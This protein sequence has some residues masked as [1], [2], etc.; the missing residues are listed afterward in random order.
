MSFLI[1]GLG[2]G[3]SLS[4]DGNSVPPSSSN[5]NVQPTETPN[6]TTVGSL[7]VSTAALP[8][9]EQYFVDGSGRSLYF[10]D[11]DAQ[12]YSA[13][14]EENN[15]ISAWPPYTVESDQSVIAEGQAVQVDIG[16]F[17]RED[18]GISSTQVTYQ[19]YPLYSYAGD[20]S[21]GETKG[22]GVNGFSLTLPQAQ[23]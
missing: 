19:G 16:S 5:P 14:G 22:N 4:L 23:E 10:Y 7:V 18:D 12:D 8:S 17:Q 15:C 20:T 21:A 3:C 2:S 9:G 13:C 1:L 11:E 6:P